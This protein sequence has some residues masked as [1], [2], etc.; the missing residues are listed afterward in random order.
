[1]SE[2]LCT[3]PTGRPVIGPASL[4]DLRRRVGA[5]EFGEDPTRL[6]VSVGFVTSQ[7][8]RHVGR[9]RVYRNELLSLRVGSAVGSCGVGAG[10]LA[11]GDLLDD[12]VGA[13]VD[14]LLTHPAAA[15]RI[16]ALDAYLMHTQ[17]HPYVGNTVA[18]PVRIPAGTSLAKSQAR[19]QAVIDLL[20][21]RPGT[22]VLVIGVVN[23]LLAQLRERGMSYLPC[24]LV[25]GRTEWGEAVRTDADALLGRCDAVLATGMT[26]SSGTFDGLI[27]QVR[28]RDLPLV[29]FAQTGSAVL[30]WFLDA[31]LSALSAEPYPFFSLDGGPSTLFHYRGQGA[32]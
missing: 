25:G 10:E 1:M 21:R 8:T 31:G 19:A 5:G 27:G 17:P 30:P 15:V 18:T 3:A 23:S 24:D 9:A 22:T 2:S 4:A 6:Q 12:C 28:A 26:L 29:M 14:E 32:A 11:A 20:P 16:A 13:P 7:G